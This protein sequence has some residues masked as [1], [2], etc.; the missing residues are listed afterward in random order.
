MK[1]N[2]IKSIG[3]V[4]AGII[5]GA[6][7]SIVTDLAL[8]KTGIFPS[9]NSGLFIWW[10]LLVALIYRGIYTVASGYI[11]AALAPDKPMRHT[12]IL[13]IIGVIVTILGSIANWDKSAAWYPITL[14][15]ITLPCTFIGGL[16]A[17]NLKRNS[18]LIKTN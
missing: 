16:I 1:N 9:S 2:I 15:L 10:M 4:L 12:I 18:D 6:L 13:G 3:A 11:T 5:S 8:E 17:T 7:M 14:I